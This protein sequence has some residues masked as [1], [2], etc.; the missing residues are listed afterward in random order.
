MKNMKR[1]KL[2]CSL[3]IMTNAEEGKKKKLSAPQSKKKGQGNII[4]FNKHPRRWHAFTN[5]PSY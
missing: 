5:N 4:Y 3:L 1:K 2:G